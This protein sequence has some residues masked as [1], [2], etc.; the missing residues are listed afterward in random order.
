MKDSD[1]TPLTFDQL[2][3]LVNESND[4]ELEKFV[5][6]I[7][8]VLW[9]LKDASTTLADVNQ[10]LTEENAREYVKRFKGVI[11]SVFFWTDRLKQ[12]YEEDVNV[13]NRI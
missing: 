13:L 5:K 1:K 10:K 2:K 9:Y 7:D 3:K 8:T 12:T 4:Q 6:T 11:A